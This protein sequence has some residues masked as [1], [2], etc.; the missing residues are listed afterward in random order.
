M[1]K[2]TK[3]TTIYTSIDQV[4]HYI[5]S[6]CYLPGSFHES[7]SSIAVQDRSIG[8][9]GKSLIIQQY[10]LVIFLL[11][12][13]SIRSCF[14]SIYRRWQWFASFMPTKKKV[15]AF[16]I[17]KKLNY[18]AVKLISFPLRCKEHVQILVTNLCRN[19]FTGRNSKDLCMN[20]I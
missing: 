19:T 20:T 17:V 9:H 1:C 13:H 6:R 5:V 4:H 8:G 15:I 11:L 12:K 10:S 16:A 14:D 7:C 2:I 3:K 18:W